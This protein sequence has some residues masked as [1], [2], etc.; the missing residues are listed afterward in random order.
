M[1]PSR[2]SKT[3]NPRSALAGATA[4]LLCAC[5]L[6]AIQT[7]PLPA[8]SVQTLD[9]QTVQ[10]SSW[11]TQ[12][13]RVLIYVESPCQPCMTVLHLLTKQDYPQLA[14]RAI[15]V[16][17]GLSPADAGNLQKQFPD[18]SAAAWYADPS[19][20]VVSSFKLQGSPVIFGI[21][22]GT[23]KWSISGAPSDSKQFKSAL[24]TWC[25]Q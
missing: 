6:G 18:L 2:S 10:S 15:V 11:P 9:G 17:G 4:F 22:N 3:W 13:K 8:F 20:N 12:G 1:F 19:K 16:A 21:E 24:N 23:V 14:S 7:M 25:A 5:A